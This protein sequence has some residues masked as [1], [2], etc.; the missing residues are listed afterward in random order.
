MTKHL[1]HNPSHR[2]PW[3]S[4]MFP[5]ALWPRHGGQI[6]PAATTAHKL[7]TKNWTQTP[8]PPPK[9]KN[10]RTDFTVSVRK[11]SVS[12][13]LTLIWVTRKEKNAANHRKYREVLNSCRVI[14]AIKIHKCL[15]ASFLFLWSLYNYISAQNKPWC[16]HFG[17]QLDSCYTSAGTICPGAASL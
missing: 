15:P 13:S 8:L 2:I 1:P 14:A 10:Y 16:L 9:K 11:H 4:Y 6:Y 7:N 17:F 3:I 5:D 12:C